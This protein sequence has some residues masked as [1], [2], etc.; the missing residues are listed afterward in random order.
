MAE[1]AQYRRPGVQSASSW[2]QIRRADSERARKEIQ[3]VASA[4]YDPVGVAER[5]S[6]HTKYEIYGTGS[7]IE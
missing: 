2:V 6:S 1:E 5:K 4:D 7:L 3:Q